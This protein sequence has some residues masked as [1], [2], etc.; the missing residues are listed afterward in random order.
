MERNDIN[1]GRETTRDGI[2]K[3]VKGVSEEGRGWMGIEQSLYSTIMRTHLRWGL[4]WCTPDA[5]ILRYRCQQVGILKG[6]KTNLK[7]SDSNYQNSI[8]YS[9]MF[10]KFYFYSLN[11]ITFR[12]TKFYF[13]LGM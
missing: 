4:H 11:V 12:R 3:R 2:R 7:V 1:L 6:H 9:D 8:F 5:N 13:Q 10:Y